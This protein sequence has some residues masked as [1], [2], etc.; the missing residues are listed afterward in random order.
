MGYP[1][2]RWNFTS[3]ALS[4]ATIK[5]TNRTPPSRRARGNSH[6]TENQHYCGRSCGVCFRGWLVGHVR[7]AGLSAWRSDKAYCGSQRRSGGRYPAAQTLN[8][9]TLVFAYTPVEVPGSLH[10]GVG[11]YFSDLGDRK[12]GR[13]IL[14]GAL[15]LKRC[16]PR[17]HRRCQ[18]RTHTHCGELCRLC[19]LCD[20]GSQDGRF[21]LRDEIIVPG[22]QPDQDAADI[23][24]S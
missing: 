6:D 9:A 22:G 12:V 3:A 4:C 24:E 2:R 19:S 15:I 13:A 21:G 16:V 8:T 5:D 23:R 7:S 20:H 18:Y 1:G 11:W 10:Q 14:S 17:A